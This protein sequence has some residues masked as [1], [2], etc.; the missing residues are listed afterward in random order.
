MA[1]KRRFGRI[2]RLPSGRWQAR[3]K[4]PDGIDRAAPSTFATKRDAEVW[5]AK[6]EV[7]ILSDQWLDPDAGAVAFGEYARS[8][9]DER[10][11]LRPKTLELYRYLLRSQLDPVFARWPVRDI[12]E[13]HVR[14]WRKDRLDVG[15]SSVTVA[16]AYRLLRAVMNTAVDDGL[17]PR[18]PCRIKGA[19]QEKSPERPVL[20]IAQ[21]FSLADA[22]TP[23]YRALILL[24]VFTGLRWGELAALRRCDID[25]DGQIVRVMRQLSEVR[26]SAPAFVAPKSEAGRRA[27]VI[28]A[29]VTPD[30]TWHLA[31]FT[32]PGDDALVFTSR[33]GAPL[34]HTNFRR[35]HWLPALRQAGLANVHFHDLRHAGNHL[36]AVGGATLREL[37]DRMG[38]STSRAALIYLHGSMERQQ[39]IADA[40]SEQ[41]RHQMASLHNTGSGKPGA[42]GSGT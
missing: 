33:N 14:R 13:P 20:T 2:R 30:L 38:H 15:V 28:P 18:N 35:R 27:V 23:Q 11:G 42:E 17:T 21:V 4:G 10:P 29:V 7:A 31:R 5:L 24:A 9:I 26:G 22:I 25:L 12:R 32:A 36:A 6:T 34:R 37:M 40:I 19:G 41:A 39:M 3:H 16:K 8:W 1:G